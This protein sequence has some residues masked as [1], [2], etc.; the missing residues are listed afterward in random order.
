MD[1]SFYVVLFLSNASADRPTQSLFDNKYASNVNQFF[2][3]AI[4][5]PEKIIKK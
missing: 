5:I 1:S 4:F 3:K 2:K